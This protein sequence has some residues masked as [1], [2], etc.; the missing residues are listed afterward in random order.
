MSIVV[1]GLHR[2]Q[3]LVGLRERMPSTSCFG[4]NIEPLMVGAQKF[5]RICCCTPSVGGLSPESSADHRRPQV[6]DRNKY[7]VGRTPS[8]SHNIQVSYLVHGGAGQSLGLH[9]DQ[10]EIP[11]EAPDALGP[12]GLE[13]HTAFLAQE[14]AKY[15]V[16]HLLAIT[17]RQ[18]NSQPRQSNKKKKRECVCVC[19]CVGV[20][21]QVHGW[22]RGCVRGCVGGLVGAW[23]GGWVRGLASGDVTYN[24]VNDR[25]THVLLSLTET[26]PTKVK[27]N[28][29]RLRPR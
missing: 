23:M 8:H 17:P 4:C 11:P 24:D 2:I 7:P 9:V 5:L 29:P 22:V 3:V 25:P 12:Q 19:A 28:R 15:V 21:A 26:A 27:H 13:I 10:G 1:L 20:G 6:D 16:H 18:Q 14:V